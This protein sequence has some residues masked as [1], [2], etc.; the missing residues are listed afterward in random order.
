MMHGFPNYAVSNVPMSV[1][2]SK[3]LRRMCV[4][5]QAVCSVPDFPVYTFPDASYHCRTVSGQGHCGTFQ[6]N[7]VCHAMK[8]VSALISRQDHTLFPAR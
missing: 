2:L 8:C 5:H 4:C 3:L 6:K 1:A 7:G